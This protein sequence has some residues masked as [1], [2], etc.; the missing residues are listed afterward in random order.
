MRKE[1]NPF[2]QEML[3]QLTGES[4][5]NVQAT[6]ENET[7]QIEHDLILLLTVALMLIPMVILM[8]TL[9]PILELVLM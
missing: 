4:K 9:T 6:F 5:R 3:A 1:A 7:N 2:F 8:L